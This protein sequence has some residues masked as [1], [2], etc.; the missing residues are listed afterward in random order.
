[1]L[2]A[3]WYLRGKTSQSHVCTPMPGGNSNSNDSSTRYHLNQTSKA[4]KCSETYGKK[5]LLSTEDE[6]ITKLNKL[7]LKNMEKTFFSHN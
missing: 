5:C 2:P 4:C 3:S 1:M 6:S 7:A